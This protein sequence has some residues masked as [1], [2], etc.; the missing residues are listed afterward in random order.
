VYEGPPYPPYSAETVI[1]QTGIYPNGARYDVKRYPKFFARDSKGRSRS[2]T[3]T[4]Q[5]QNNWVTIVDNI[6]GYIYHLDGA[7]PHVA[8]RYK[9]TECEKVVR[10]RPDFPSILRVFKGIR[11]GDGR[12]ILVEDLGT[13]VIE[14]L[15]VRGWRTTQP[16]G[17]VAVITDEAWWFEELD[18]Y[19][20]RIKTDPMGETTDRMINIRRAEPDPSLFEVPP[21][22][23][24][25]DGRTGE[26][27]TPKQLR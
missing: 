9:Q 11:T 24:I 19:V 26:R 17:P 23:Q 22:Y 12:E 16:I 3:N 8:R 10:P 21:D 2:E 14:G 25:V 7:E 15:S 6:A 1:E 18:V 13:R 27:V 5:P 20:L 4:A